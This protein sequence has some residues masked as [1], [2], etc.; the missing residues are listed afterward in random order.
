MEL[1]ALK[2]AG[3]PVFHAFT[4]SDTTS[5]FRGKAKKTCFKAWDDYEPIS[6]VFKTI[7]D[8]PFQKIGLNDPHFQTIERYTIKIFQPQCPE[9]SINKAKKWIFTNKTKDVGKLPP[10]QV[11]GGQL[12]GKVN[13]L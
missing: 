3:L 9:N 12:D 5:A 6:E 4:G 8:N 1:G 7:S 2:C 11:V 10:T 13:K